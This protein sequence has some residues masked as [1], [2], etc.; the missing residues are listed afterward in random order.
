M[1]CLP[2][3]LSKAESLRPHPATT[4]FTSTAELRPPPQPK[5]QILTETQ[6]RKRKR[7]HHSISTPSFNSC[8]T[9]SS[10]CLV[11]ETRAGKERLPELPSSETT[12]A[13]KK[14]VPFPLP[15]ASPTCSP[16]SRQKPSQEKTGFP[17]PSSSLLCSLL[18]SPGAS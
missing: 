4:G 10:H 9:I 6:N 14:P 17:V 12:G 13:Q 16:V 7:P 15:Q 18:S 3:L 5:T 8:L 2:Q 1:V 11:L